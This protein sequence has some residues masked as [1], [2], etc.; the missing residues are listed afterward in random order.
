MSEAALI[1]NES[2]EPFGRRESI[3]IL[4]NLA[5]LAA[6][7]VV[8][9]AFLSLLGPPSRLLVIA[10][11][12]RFVML[13]AELIWLQKQKP[14]L[15]PVAEQYYACYSIITN[16]AFAFMASYLGGAA[17]SHYSVLMVLPVIAAATRFDLPGTL[18]VVSIA[19]TLTF[20]EVWLFFRSYPP[21]E[22]SE[23]FEAA[24]VSLIFIVVALV[25]RL[26][27]GNLRQ[28]ELKLA[29][30]L[31][32]LKKVQ[33]KLVAEEKL[34]A[35]GRLSSAIAHEI[36][37]PVA[38]ISSSLT[39]GKQSEDAEVRDEMFNI[40]A[41][42]ATRLERLTTDFLSYARGKEPERKWTNPALTLGYV[43]GLLRDRATDAG[44]TI[45]VDY[46]DDA[47]ANV[48]DFQIQQALLNLMTNA[49]EATPRGGKVRLGGSL[50][51]RRDLVLF[52]ENEGQQIHQDV[53][54]KIFEP[55]FSTRVKGTGLGLAIVRNIAQAHGGSVEI[56]FNQPGRVRFEIIIPEAGIKGGSDGAH[57]DR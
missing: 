3:L 10:L 45:I 51:R 25:V 19:V 4:L 21:L 55:F 16:I 8:H 32:T 18:L 33:S 39:A 6:L 20:L 24:T 23:F 7:L 5:V 34:A 11:A 14:G 35:I 42:E 52:V 44:I 28:E 46:P 56:A 2:Q 50:N 9:T 47:P 17:D 38:M 29:K 22:I 26:L 40:A 15:N 12:T 13:F 37:N 1:T 36:R 43:A 27:V 49:I 54:S 30:S 48:D 57:P 53:L 31:E 41:Q